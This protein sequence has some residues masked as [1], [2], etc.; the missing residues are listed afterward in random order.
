[1]STGNFKQDVHAKLAR[2]DQRR[3]FTSPRRWYTGLIAARQD[4]IRKAKARAA[5]VQH[6]PFKSSA[7]GAPMWL[8]I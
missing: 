7:A 3:Y 8:A 5:R 4:P 2:L 6:S 1:M